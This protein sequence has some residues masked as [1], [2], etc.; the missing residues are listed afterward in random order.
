MHK[1][2][3]RTHTVRLTHLHSRTHAR[4]RTLLHSNQVG[5]SAIIHATAKQ[6]KQFV[7]ATPMATATAT[8]AATA[9]H[10]SALT[11]SKHKCSLNFPIVQ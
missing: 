8:A 7:A 3:P 10:T 5:R 6:Q 2:H 1:M 11:A 9:S 4:T